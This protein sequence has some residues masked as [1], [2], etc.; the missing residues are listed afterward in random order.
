[1]YSGI[2]GY[3]PQMCQQAA[4]DAEP[5]VVLFDE[6]GNFR[7]GIPAAHIGSRSDGN[8]TIALDKGADEDD[9]GVEIGFAEAF[10]IRRRNLLF[11][12]EEAQI[13]RFGIKLVKGLDQQ[14]GILR[15]HRADANRKAVAQGFMYQIVACV[16][17]GFAP[18][19]CWHRQD[20]RHS[21]SILL[22]LCDAASVDVNAREPG[23]VIAA[24]HQLISML[25]SAPSA[26]FISA[27]VG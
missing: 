6:K 9:A 26:R 8:F 2:R 19:L 20:I 11:R 25:T 3:F 24:C 1:M 13:D 12:P 21:I 22:Q 10:Q 5:V 23:S 16:D 7:D 15:S 17:H 27:S 4:G 14:V 18:L